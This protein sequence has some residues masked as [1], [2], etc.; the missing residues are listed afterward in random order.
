MHGPVAHAPTYAVEDVPL[1]HGL[2]A[3]VSIKGT[4]QHHAGTQNHGEQHAVQH[5]PRH[6]TYPKPPLMASPQPVPP[7]LWMA[8]QVAP[9]KLS[10]ITFW[11]AMSAPRG[12]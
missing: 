10:P 9:R 11:M 1:Q 4:I 7:P 2:S 6:V 12:T 3:A 5:G 8:T